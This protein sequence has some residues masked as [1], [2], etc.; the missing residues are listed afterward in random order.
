MNDIVQRNLNELTTIEDLSRFVLVGREK[1]IA[2][3]AEIR[4]IDKLELAQEVRRQKKE[5]A[6]MFSEALLDAEVKLGEMMKQIPKNR[7]FHGNQHHEVTAHQCTN[8]KGKYETAAEIGFSPDQVK[9]FETLANNPDLVEQVKAEAREN[10]DLPTRTA[11][12]NLA[13]ARDAR[14]RQE[15][16]DIDTGHMYYKHLNR[17]ER[18]LIFVDTDVRELRLLMEA[19]NPNDIADELCDIDEALGKL[20]AIK[21][22]LTKGAK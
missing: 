14:N 22:I 6:A 1:L 5:E 4:A 21:S 17:A 13:K 20:G 8:T 2:V 10:D 7:E 18:E 19:M 3:K 11:V 9:R 16:D 15:F 12:L